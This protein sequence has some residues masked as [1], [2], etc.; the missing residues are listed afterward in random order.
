MTLKGRLG[1]IGLAVAA[2]L[3]VSSGTLRRLVWYDSAPWS[4][5]QA[6]WGGLEL[7]T[8]MRTDRGVRIPVSLQYEKATRVDS[9][10]S[11]SGIS[12]AVVDNELRLRMSRC[13]CDSRWV[14]KGPLVLEL[15]A[16]PPGKYEVAYEDDSVHPISQQVD[17][18]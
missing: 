17:V 3:A 2:C 18:P 9:A 12:G 13:I 8:P 5:V 10:I 15:G 7:G 6:A 14:Q 16:V 11:L 4:Y 1:A